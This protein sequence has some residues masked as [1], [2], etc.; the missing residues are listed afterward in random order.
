MHRGIV[1][2]LILVLASPLGC[3]QNEAAA[4]LETVAEVDCQPEYEPTFENIYTR[5]LLARCAVGGGACHLAG[6]AH[7]GLVLDSI[8]AAYS[9]LVSDGRVVSMDPNCSIL[10]DRIEREGQPGLMPPNNP[11]SEAERC[12]V[13]LWVRGGA[14]R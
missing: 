4:C 6:A 1:W 11:L 2:A 14:L 8:E 13:T 3:A 10:I 9:G 12:A 5:T 7:G